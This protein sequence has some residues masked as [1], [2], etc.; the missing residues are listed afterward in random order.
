MKSFD[1]KICVVTGAASGIG[2]AT[3]RRLHREGAKLVLTD[4]DAGGLEEVAREVGAL[5]HE[6][7][8]IADAGA[9]V[10]FAEAAHA[11]CGGSVDVVMN[12]AGTSLW[13]QIKH[14]ENEHWRKMVDI[15][16]M[17]PIYVMQAFVPAMIRAG[18]G[19]HVVNVSSAAGLLGLPWHAPYSAS[20][21][22]IRGV[23]EVLRFDLRR[24]GIGVSLVCPGAVDTPLVRTITMVGVDREHPSAKKATAGFRRHAKSPE[25]V[26]KAIL[27][28]VKKRRYVIYTSPDIWAG[29][30][31][32]RIFPP[33]YSLVMRLLNRG[34]SRVLGPAT[35]P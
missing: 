5:H 33:G 21:F 34:Y 35:R 20:K 14:L 28:G 1:G 18:R 26:A 7:F 11:T 13:G 16:L 31:L 32:Q 12:V 3:A 2:R 27:E 9:V 4:I 22:G 19:G 24:Y 8:D 10:A 23:S 15:N 29:F 6:A 17:G 30:M 25:Q